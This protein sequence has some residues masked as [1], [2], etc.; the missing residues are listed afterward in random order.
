MKLMANDS[1]PR[2]CDIILGMKKS[3]AIGLVALAAGTARA[4]AI[5]DGWLTVMNSN[6]AAC[7]AAD[8][9][10][11]NVRCTW[12]GADTKSAAALPANAAFQFAIAGPNDSVENVR[13]ILEEVTAAIPTNITPV[14]RRFN[15]LGPTLQWIVRSAK[16]KK[17]GRADYLWSSTHPAAFLTTDFSVNNLLAFTRNIT[18]AQIPPAA[19]IR[20]EGEETDMRQTLVPAVPGVDYPGTLPELTFATPFGIGMVVRAPETPR[21]FRI[22]AAA[23]PAS[24]A[25]VTFTWA[26]LTGGAK[27]QG[28]NSAKQ[29]KNG[30]GRIVLDVPT[31]FSKRRVDVAVFVRWGDGPWGAPSIISFYASPYESRIYKKGALEQIMYF[32]KAKNPP[33]CDI[34]AI[35]TPANWTD[36]YLCNEKRE[37]IGF[38]RILP[39]ELRG[40][41]FSFRNERIISAHP[42]DLPKVAEKMRYF[43]R[44]GQLQCEG[45]GEEVTYKPSTFQPRRLAAE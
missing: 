18:A 4:D 30:Y 34:S 13:D 43:V 44:D 32:P 19:V 38:T 2:F 14:I 10:T 33:P 35:C 8:Y 23:F 6:T 45:T 36:A 27:V 20:L 21:T 12:A 29:A 3:L 16:C 31:L 15:L 17:P 24:D 40:T 5:P 25:P 39:D 37:P 9:A 1:E 28:W 7:V 22:R 41:S 42:N 11:N 26:V